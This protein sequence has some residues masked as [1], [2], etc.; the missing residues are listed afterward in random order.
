MN[1]Y[2]SRIQNTVLDILFPP[3][4]TLCG[5]NL[6]EGMRNRGICE[7]CLEAIPV[8]DTLTC[9]ICGARMAENTKICHKDT[10][11]R[12]AAALPYNNEKVKT[13]IWQLKYE[14][15]T[16][17]A[18]PLV[19]LMIHHLKTLGMNIGNYIV[20]PVP[21]HASRERER[22]FN[23]AELIA[24]PLARELGLSLERKSLVRVKKTASQ[25]E[26]KNRQERRKN[27]EGSFSV[28]HPERIQGKD[29]LLIDDVFTSGATAEAA[30]AALKDTGAKKVIVAVAARA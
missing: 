25:A 24:T 19:Y 14:K 13:L 5:K 16:Y 18:R 1:L 9:P 10:P 27:L 20:V 17:A 15:K 2:L 11:F 30:V 6:K 26:T 29:I 22:G 23:Q 21:L 8:K 7:M 12:L 3:L 4:C 28:R